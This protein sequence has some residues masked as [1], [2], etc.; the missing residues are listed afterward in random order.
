[1]QIAQFYPVL[2][3]EDVPATA[4]FYQHHFGFEAAFESDWYVHLTMPG[5][6]PV[7]LAILDGRHDTIPAMARGKVTGMLLNFEVADVD[8]VHE[9]LSAAGLPILLPL[10]DEDF[11][12][13]HFITADPN[14]VLIDVITPIAPSADYAAQYT[15]EALPG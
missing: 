7:N 2:M 8:A 9:T 3:V 1:M 5:A 12:Q 14:G 6:V 4:A 10:R 15:A 11:G 13:R